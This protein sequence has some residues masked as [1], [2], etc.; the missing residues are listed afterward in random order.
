MARFHEGQEVAVWAGPPG[1]VPNCGWRE[2][3]IVCKYPYGEA[4]LCEFP[5][6]TS[7]IFH[8]EKIREKKP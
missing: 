8:N 5:D 3:K 6:G 2:A 7:T 4:W 1:K